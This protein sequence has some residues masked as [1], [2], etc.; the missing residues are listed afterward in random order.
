[1]EQF[2]KVLQELRIWLHANKWIKPL[3]PFRLILLF[4]GLGVKLFYEIIFYAVPYRFD[5]FHRFLSNTYYE[6]PISTLVDFSYLL[7]LWLTLISK[8]IK[9]VAYALWA[10]AFIRLY[11]FTYFDLGNI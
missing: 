5:V 3:I 6:V 1:M 9:L 11:P 7:G 4:G 10:V 2:S 8:D